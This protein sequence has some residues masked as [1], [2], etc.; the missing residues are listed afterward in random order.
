MNSEKNRAF[1]FMRN[2]LIA[3]LVV[4]LLA[5]TVAF[6]SE[7][8]DIGETA[9]PAGETLDPPEAPTETPAEAPS[10][11]ASETPSTAPS[12]EPLT[13]PTEEPLP[14]EP[15]TTEA[16]AP[17]ETPIAEAPS[18]APVPSAMP[19][20]AP[21]QEEG[22]LSAQA[23]APLEEPGMSALS[24]FGTLSVPMEEQIVII[25]KEREPDTVTAFSA[26]V[27]EEVTAAEVV[28]DRVTAVQV[29]TGTDTAAFMEEL[30]ANPAVETVQFNQTYETHEVAPSDYGQDSIF[31]GDAFSLHGVP[32]EFNPASMPDDPGFRTTNILKLGKVS[33]Y[34][35]YSETGPFLPDIWQY[36]ATGAYNTW[37]MKG[38]APVVVAVID[39]GVQTTHPDL[40]G[41]IAIGY[42]YVTG[43]ARVTDI[44][45]HGTAVAGCIVA[46]ANN[47]RGTAGIAGMADIKIAP[48]RV[49]NGVANSTTLDGKKI[50][51]ALYNAADREDVRVI[52]MSFG[53]ALAKPDLLLEEAIRYAYAKG[54]MLVASCGNY[55]AVGSTTRDRTAYNYPASYDNVVSVAAIE[56]KYGS[57]AEPNRII[58]QTSPFSV[59]NDKV[60]LCAPG[61]NLYTTT[62][63]GRF[64]FMDG[65]SFASPIVA[66]CAALV[67]AVN[68][69]YSP[70]QVESLLKTA[71]YDLKYDPWTG[72]DN[73]AYTG[74]DD[75]YGYGLVQVDTALGKGQAYTPTSSVRLNQTSATLKRGKR[76]RLEAT[77][78]PSD[79]SSMDVVWE[80]SKPEVATVT[81]GGL[82]RARA[83]G[84]TVITA[85]TKYEGVKAKCTITVGT[86]VSK[87]KLNKARFTLR[88]RK[89]YRLKATVLPS[90]ASNKAITW[91]SSNP[92]IATVS[93]KGVVTAKKRGK[94]TISAISKDRKVTGKCRLT[95]K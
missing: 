72:K 15:G 79:A 35:N 83:K 50:V 33:R 43:S 46:A 3:V 67:F 92:S 84:K 49:D 30:R 71:A 56:Y 28:S 21:P 61:S 23:E 86:P 88:R 1:P 81:S 66:G 48:Y 42:D 26:E 60:D 4:T 24:D 39:T 68:P 70:K 17:T 73:F 87:V 5:P 74:K 45:G 25:Y 82:V 58:L 10:A 95:V 38:N 57:S 18:A 62:L 80:S 6:A 69:T 85:T 54:K 36:S 41:R 78:F 27:L 9:L 20:P 75:Y 59:Y 8:V 93:R 22:A 7:P 51:A 52:N 29:A 64:D 31:Y 37:T 77:V 65:T 14:T 32:P 19:E 16:P 13:T 89:K 11:A 76:Y 90:K 53:F 63:G 34:I 55:R 12:E 94:V 44:R 2:L 47:G 40:Q 91:K